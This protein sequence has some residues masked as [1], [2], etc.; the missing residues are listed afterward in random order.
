MLRV[1]SL[2]VSW[3]GDTTPFVR[4][5]EIGAQTLMRDKTNPVRVTTTTAYSLM[6]DKTNPVRVTTLQV[7]VLMSLTEEELAVAQYQQLPDMERNPYRPDIPTEELRSVSPDLEHF[8]REQQTHH[9]IQHNL[10]Q[11]GDTTYPAAVMTKVNPEQEFTLGV[12]GRF[13]HEDFGLIRARYVQ[14][15][16]MAET[17]FL[18]APVGF[19]KSSE[20]LDWVVTN[21][22]GKSDPMLAV[23]I[24]ACFTMPPEGWYGWV[25]VD[26]GNI[27]SLGVHEYASYESHGGQGVRYG[28]HSTGILGH[29]EPS[30]VLVRQTKK[31][32]SGLQLDPGE[33]YILV[34]GFSDAYVVGLTDARITALAEQVEDL[35]SA[36]ETLEGGDELLSLQ[37][38]LKSIQT[39]LTNLASALQSE[40]KQRADA[41]RS[42][43][44]KITNGVSEQDLAIALQPLQTTLDSLAIAIAA[45][46]ARADAAFSIANSIDVASIQ[47]LL[48][49]FNL[50]LASF[51][52]RIQKLERR[53]IPL[54]DGSVPPNL[55]YLPD[56]SLV[57]TE[58]EI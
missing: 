21:D 15:S 27:A 18:N 7:Y 1:T 39:K 19:F 57:F 29:S 43:S 45:A 42:L 47:N 34:D 58:I 36:V 54:V 41:D 12:I 16:Q 23:G 11:V 14:F 13:F 33:A 5:T 32:D 35:Q 6:R 49:I 50:T 51:G 46:K 26:G 31:G 38:T 28:W 52:E 8:F 2:T 55:V 4:V 37:K 56:G 30:R 40:G 20:T 3:F 10:T 24:M 25:I 22:Y 9:R 17:P 44:L 53:L 48:D